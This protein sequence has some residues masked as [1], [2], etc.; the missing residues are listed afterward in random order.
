MLVLDEN[1]PAGQQNLLRKWRIRFRFIGREL[2][3][4]GGQDE[5]L[6]RLLHRLPHPT[7]FTLDRDFCRQD[8]CH[9]NYCLIWLD[10]R[11]QEAAEFVRRVLRYPVLNTE[12]K[13]MGV[14][15]RAHADGVV[16]WQA[17]KGT[18]L[19]VAWPAR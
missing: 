11:R 5:D 15:A 18:A 12:A 16:Y 13:R 1:L 3:T 2:G 7:F 19:S 10:V 17:P 8:W 9:P 14:V 6:I 4:S